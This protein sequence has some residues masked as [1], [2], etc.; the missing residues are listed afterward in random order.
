MARRLV[1]D[2]VS[3]FRFECVDVNPNVLD[4]GRKARGGGGTDPALRLRPVAARILVEA[5][6]RT[7]VSVRLATAPR[8]ARTTGSELLAP[9]YCPIT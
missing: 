4:R 9:N 8:P 1:Q 7:S 5:P 3:N 6:S 2:G